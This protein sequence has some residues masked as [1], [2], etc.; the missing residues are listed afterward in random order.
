MDSFNESLLQLI[1]MAYERKP[2][3][4]RIVKVRDSTRLLYM[5]NSLQLF[6]LVAE[7]FYKYSKQLRSKNA[8]FFLQ[9]DFSSHVA[10]NEEEELI[11][12]LISEVRAMYREASNAEREDMW[13]II[14]G[15]RNSMD[16][17][18]STSREVYGNI[19][20]HT[21]EGEDYDTY[22]RKARAANSINHIKSK[23]TV[24]IKD[25]Q[26]GCKNGKTKNK[27]SR[28]GKKERS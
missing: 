10:G 5:S 9:T 25:E 18:F 19:W 15:M 17:F 22:L 21:L 16:L 26:E 8:D 1:D 3:D 4:W 14:I 27:K 6:L 12:G 2:T 20:Y 13:E 24:G 7:Y 28:Q 23:D 11:Q